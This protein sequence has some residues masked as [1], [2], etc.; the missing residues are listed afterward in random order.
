MD[1]L[2][3]ICQLASLGV[4]YRSSII[5]KYDAVSFWTGDRGW[6]ITTDRYRGSALKIVCPDCLS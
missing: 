2:L 4:S 3:R 5:N 6:L 1:N